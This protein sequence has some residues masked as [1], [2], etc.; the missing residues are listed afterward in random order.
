MVV[1]LS[2]TPEKE[3]AGAPE[4]QEMTTATAGKALAHFLVGPIVKAR[5]RCY[6]CGSSSRRSSKRST[7]KVGKQLGRGAP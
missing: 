2:E 1:A 5:I 7:S 4:G 6:G 3:E